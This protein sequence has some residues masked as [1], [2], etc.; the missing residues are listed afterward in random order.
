MYEYISIASPA[1]TP[2]RYGLGTA[3]ASSAEM[4]KALLRELEKIDSFAFP[5]NAFD[6]VVLSYMK[7]HCGKEDYPLLRHVAPSTEGAER[8]AHDLL[9]LSTEE[10]KLCPGGALGVLRC[11]NFCVN[12][13][14]L[15][16]RLPLRTHL[17]ARRRLSHRAWQWEAMLGDAGWAGV[18]AEYFL[19]EPDKCLYLEYDPEYIDCY[20]LLEIFREV[21]FLLPE[22]KRVDFTFTTAFF[23]ETENCSCFM[24]AVP[25]GSQTAAELRKNG[26]AWILSPEN[27]REIPAEY[28]ASMLVR[29]AR[30]MKQEC[31]AVPM[32]STQIDSQVPDFS[33]EEAASL[34]GGKRKLPPVLRRTAL[35]QGKGKL[36]WVLYGIAIFFTILLFVLLYFFIQTV[37]RASGADGD[38]VIIHESTQLN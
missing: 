10:L 27:C 28:A 17:K 2:E 3:V 35:P 21:T 33:P 19:N 15:P 12:W 8:I 22:E 4:P 5:G 24:R 20:G 13:E 37:D 31:P 11:D 26:T 6:P 29:L 23:Q 34:D 36:L 1:A 18:A 38:V 25:A 7:L 14:L 32:T 9:F 30:E 16:E